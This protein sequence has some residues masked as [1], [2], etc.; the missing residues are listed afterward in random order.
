MKIIHK[1]VIGFVCVAA[2]AVAIA[3]PKSKS[4]SELVELP[5]DCIECVS[6]NDCYEIYII[7]EDG[8]VWSLYTDTYTKPDTKFIVVFDITGEPAI[9]DCILDTNAR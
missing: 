9:V 7:T 3:N 1:I 2:I 5:T 8:N 6:V 4:K